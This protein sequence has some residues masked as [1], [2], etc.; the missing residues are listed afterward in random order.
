MGRFAALQRHVGRGRAVNSGSSISQITIWLNAM[1]TNWELRG[2]RQWR[3]AICF[4]SACLFAALDL[5]VDN[6]PHEGEVPLPA[7]L[8]GS[9]SRNP[10][11]NNRREHG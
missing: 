5:A 9:K 3:V 6:L 4:S 7:R 2:R 10:D 11:R 1:L 8:G